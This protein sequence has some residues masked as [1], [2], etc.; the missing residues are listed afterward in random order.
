MTEKTN[1]I[2][3]D[4]KAV[5]AEVAHL[6]AKV[7]Q[8]DQTVLDAD[9]QEIQMLESRV[10]DEYFT[11]YLDEVKTKPFRVRACLSEQEMEEIQQLQEKKDAAVSRE[12]QENITYTILS[13]IAY[14]KLLRDPEWFRQNKAKYSSQDMLTI[15]IAYLDNMAERAQEIVKLQNF[16]TR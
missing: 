2:V 16:R 10:Q 13:K 4:S 7:K 14:N 12:E 1:G 5:L 15:F 8:F 6:E 11:I 3:P 9:M